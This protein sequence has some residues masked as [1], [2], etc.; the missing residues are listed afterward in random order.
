MKYVIPRDAVEIEYH[1]SAFWRQFDEVE[2]EIPQG[3][4]LCFTEGGIVHTFD[5]CQSS[6]HGEYVSEYREEYREAPLPFSADA[7]ANARLMRSIVCSDMK[8]KLVRK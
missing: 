2:V 6:G 8:A 1:G 5:Y 4:F 3:W 7:Q